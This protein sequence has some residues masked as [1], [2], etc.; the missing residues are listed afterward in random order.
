MFKFFSQP[1]F[2]F[3]RKKRVFS[4]PVTPQ[5]EIQ[6]PWEV[7]SSS[8][9]LVLGSKWIQL[10]W[11]FLGTPTGGRGAEFHQLEILRLLFPVAGVHFCQYCVFLPSTFGKVPYIEDHFPRKKIT[12]FFF[13]MKGAINFLF[14]TVQNFDFLA[15]TITNVVGVCVCTCVCAC[16]YIT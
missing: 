1:L 12:Q 2:Y 14:L 10:G 6:R 3:Q 16:K 8:F 11:R 15:L 7:W 4:L 5:W 9:P 13:R